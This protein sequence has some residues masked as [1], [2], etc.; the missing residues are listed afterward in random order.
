MIEQLNL[1]NSFWSK[2][3]DLHLNLKL[4]TLS[5]LWFFKKLNLDPK[6]HIAGKKIVD[7]IS[8]QRHKSVRAFKIK[9]FHHSKLNNLQQIL[10]LEGIFNV[11]LI[12]NFPKNYSSILTK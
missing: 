11:K 4:P 12:L 7:Q 9:K 2:C 6:C 8:H 10:I 5:V 1:M 3:M